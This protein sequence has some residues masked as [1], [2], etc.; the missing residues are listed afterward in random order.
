MAA[1]GFGSVESLTV[2]TPLDY[3]NADDSAGTERVDRIVWIS[4]GLAGLLLGQLRVRLDPDLN[5]VNP[6]EIQTILS[7]LSPF[8]TRL[9]N[10]KEALKI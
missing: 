1:A 4:R 7:T 2:E 6:R 5:P 8:R 10:S 9:S 3:E